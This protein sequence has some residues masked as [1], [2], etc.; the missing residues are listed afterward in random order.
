VARHIAK[1]SRS[2]IPPRPPIVRTVNAAVP[3][4][5]LGSGTQPQLP[6]ESRR[7][8]VGHLRPLDRLVPVFSRPVGPAV[9]LADLA[10]RAI[11]NQFDD[12][13]RAIEGVPLIAHLRDDVHLAG[14][15]AHPSR[16]IDRVRERLLAIHVLAHPHGQHTGRRVVVVGSRDDDRVDIFAL[17]E[18]FAV[19]FVLGNVRIFLVCF[20][21]PSVVRVA[22]RNDVFV[23]APGDIDPAFSAGTDR[24]DVELFVGRAAGRANGRS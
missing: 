11:A 13:P 3:V 9:D 8:G 7:N 18:H 20:G 4:R 6:I 21:G 12:P 17:L 23:R 24:G 22:Q 1:R 2:K 16:L 10:D 15:F 14:D 19:V 5:P